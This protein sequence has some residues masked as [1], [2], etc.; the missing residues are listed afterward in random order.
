[1]PQPKFRLCKYIQLADGSWRYCKAGLYSNG[2]CAQPLHCLQQR[3]RNIPRAPIIFIITRA[4]FP[5]AQM[6]WMHNYGGMQ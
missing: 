4:G 1:M 2:N 6:H 3:R 5:S